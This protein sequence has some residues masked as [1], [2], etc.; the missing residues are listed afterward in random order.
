[1]YTVSLVVND[2]SVDSTPPA[3]VQVTVTNTAPV[4]LLSGPASGFKLTALT[5]N[6]SG[7]SDANGDTLSYRWDFGDGS[8]ATTSTPTTTHSYAAVGTYQVT[9]T[10]NDGEASSAPA[11]ANVSIQSKPPVA[12]AGPDQTV[13]QRTAVALNGATSNDPDGTI[14]GVRWVQVAGPAVTLSGS[15]TL[16]PTFEAPRV[17]QTSIT[18]TFELTV[19]DNDGVSSSDRVNVNVTRK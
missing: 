6:A 12:N 7:S 18:L 11:T 19:T 4:A 14:A 3:R 13:T 8:S 15:T 2:G 5:W 9:L 17:Q 16:S 10:V 1:V